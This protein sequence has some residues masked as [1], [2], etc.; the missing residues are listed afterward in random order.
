MNE[1]ANRGSLNWVE[2]QDNPVLSI[3][4]LFIK[5]RR[6]FLGLVVKQSNRSRAIAI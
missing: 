5:V 3:N 4:I 6:S 1:Y 2:Q